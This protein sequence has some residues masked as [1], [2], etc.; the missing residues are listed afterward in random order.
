MNAYPTRVE[1]HSPENFSRTQLLLRIAI[2]IVLSW[3]RITVGWLAWALYFM[4]PVIAAIAVSARTDGPRLMQQTWRVV[5]WLLAFWAYMFLLVDRLP[6]DSADVKV[7][8]ESSGTPTV[9]SA[10]VRIVT[11][12]PSA[13]VLGILWAVGWILWII[14]A[15]AVLVAA[16]VPHGILAYQRGVLRWNANLAAYLSSRVSE[17]P[18]FALDTGEQPI[19]HQLTGTTEAPR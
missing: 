1:V 16:R 6:T 17:Y 15:V 19:D 8:V 18:P 9:G 10:L 2:G 11:A 14:A 5:R 13:F 7:E 3:S 4:L 12:I